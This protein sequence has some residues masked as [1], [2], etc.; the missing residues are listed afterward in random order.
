MD[1]AGDESRVRRE[2]HIRMVRFA[3]HSLAADDDVMNCRKRR[4]KTAGHVWV[5]A[6][7]GSAAL[8]LYF[9]FSYKFHRRS[10]FNMII[11]YL[12]NSPAVSITLYTRPFPSAANCFYPANS[13]RQN[14]CSV[15]IH[16]H[17][18]VRT[19]YRHSSPSLSQPSSMNTS[20]TTST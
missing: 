6:R 4:V 13:S 9:Y 2:Q 18:S 1:H 15:S 20:T 14:R 12:H 19:A 11:I 17:C 3:E 8:N 7:I 16:P 10:L 5:L